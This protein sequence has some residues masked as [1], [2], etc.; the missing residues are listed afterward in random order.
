[1]G[2]AYSTVACYAVIVTLNIIALVRNSGVMP[3]IWKTLGKPVIAGVLC[4]ITA[5]VSA[6]LLTAVVGSLIVKLAISVILAAFVYIFVLFAL[7]TLTK[8]DI[9]LLPKGE[10]I[11]KVLEK[12]K[13]LG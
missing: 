12:L 9:N 11:A 8:E 2:A 13:L 4:M 6:S 1:M 5:M 7:K 3:S 10:K